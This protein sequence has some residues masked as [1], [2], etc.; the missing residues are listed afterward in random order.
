MALLI[1]GGG[2]VYICSF[3]EVFF[4]S[5]FKRLPVADRVTMVGLLYAMLDFARDEKTFEAYDRMTAHEVCM[6][7]CM[8]VCMCVCMI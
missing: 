5:N 4:F 2:F 8:Y 6:Y 3:L 7:V 1:G